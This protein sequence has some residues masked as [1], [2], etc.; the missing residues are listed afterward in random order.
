MQGPTAPTR[1]RYSDPNQTHV[2]PTE[3]GIKR[4]QS[5]FDLHGG[6]RGPGN[7]SPET[8]TLRIDIYYHIS[9]ESADCR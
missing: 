2:G 4:Y 6:A 1:P 9:G 3:R 5:L 7:T 8:W